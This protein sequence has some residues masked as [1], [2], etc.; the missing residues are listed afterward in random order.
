M[1]RNDIIEKLKMF[2]YDSK[3]YWVITGAAMVLYGIR[4]VTHDIDMGCTADMADK[5]E[6][7]GYLY[8]ITSDGNRRFKIGDDIEVFEN[9]LFGKVVSVEGI[10]V[11][12]IKGLIEM[13]QKLGREKDKRD[14]RLIEEYIHGTENVCDIVE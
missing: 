14:I 9:W 13:K 12:S 10:P 8:K 5:L 7:A 1:N 11:I 6:K 3:D 4:E 2:P